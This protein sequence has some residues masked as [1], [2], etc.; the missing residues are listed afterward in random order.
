[1]ARPSE[2]QSSLLSKATMTRG[3]Y[4]TV[5]VKQAT[6]ALQ[7]E[8]HSIRAAAKSLGVPES[9]IRGH[10]KRAEGD[11]RRK[12]NKGQPRVV[13]KHSRR[14]LGA[15][16]DKQLAGFTAEMAQTNFFRNH[17]CLDHSR[18][19]SIRTV[20]RELDTLPNVAKGM[21][22][23]R[24]E[25]TENQKTRRLEYCHANIDTSFDDAYFGDEIYL[26]LRGAFPWRPRY[27]S[28]TKFPHGPPAIP[29][30]EGVDIH[31]RKQ[32]GRL[33]LHFW[34]AVSTKSWSPLVE[35]SGK[36]TGDVYRNRMLRQTLQA[37]IIQDNM[38]ES[39]MIVHDEDSAHKAH[40]TTTTL[41]ELHITEKLLGPKC[42]ILN[43]IERVWGIFVMELYDFGHKTYRNLDELR[44]A[45]FATWDAVKGK[46]HDV[47]AKM[48]ADLPR[49][50]QRMIDAQGGHID[51]M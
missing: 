26:G 43:P 1:M 30:A 32:P 6:S 36:L 9:T 51:L 15:W 10:L 50:M 16:V 47:V 49:D 14:R 11:D 41:D 23:P 44:D 42:W 21:T 20:R 17:E 31:K 13:N 40:E 35:Y 29:V 34:A 38:Q 28:R 3:R 19:P 18:V 7:K 45:A 4:T 8:H 27:Y 33:K 22:R 12:Q 48:L 24:T 39:A 37:L 25:F 46:H 5:S 2:N